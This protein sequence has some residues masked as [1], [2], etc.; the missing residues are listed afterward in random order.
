MRIATGASLTDGVNECKQ[1]ENV[2]EA[3]EIKPASNAVS[4]NI[5]ALG[6]SDDT[7]SLWNR[8]IPRDVPF[9]QMTLFD[10]LL[11]RPY[12]AIT[13][14]GPFNLTKLVQDHRN[15][16]FRSETIIDRNGK[17]RI[18]RLLLILEGGGFGYLEGDIFKI[19]APTPDAAEAAGRQFRRYVK[20]EPA[21]K[22]CFYVIS[23]Q[24]DGPTTEM[25]AIE[26]SVPVTT[27][28]LTLNYGEDFPTWEQQ[29]YAR[30]RFWKMPRNC[31]SPATLAPEIRWQHPEP[32]RRVFR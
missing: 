13:L 3:T 28:D 32:C 19:Y 20:P 10:Q 15:R 12:H 27:E 23:L 6:E 4:S 17:Q 24:P 21:P 2:R 1:M 16:T 22:P 31:C 30:W 26:G 18:D 9:F 7:Q 29:L 5:E 25:V 14:E 11:R 8:F